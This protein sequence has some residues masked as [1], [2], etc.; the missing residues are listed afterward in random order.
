MPPEL[1]TARTS[2]PEIACEAYG[3]ATGAPVILLHGFPDDARAYDT[4]R[5]RSRPPAIACWSTS[6]AAMVPRAFSPTR[7]AH[8]PAGRHRPGLLDLIAALDLPPVALGGLQTGAAEQPPASR[9]HPRAD[10]VRGWLGTMRRLHVHDTLGSPRPADAIQ[11]RAKLVSVG[12]QY[13]ARTAGPREE[14]PRDLPAA[15][16][17]WSP[18]GGSTTRPSTAPAVLRHS[19]LRA[20]RIH[21]YRHRHRHAPA[22]RASRHRAPAGRP[23]A[24]QRPVDDPHGART[25]WIGRRAPRAPQL[26]PPGPSAAWWRGRPLMPREQPGAVVDALKACYFGRRMVTSECPPRER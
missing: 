7:A 24:H 19:R 12:L 3:L 18:A 16:A 4:V 11:E 20:H 8:G 23:A 14:S 21:S 25:R 10:R 13:R 2:T 26:L 1:L 5:R 17:D 22:I 15:L 9:R 6:S